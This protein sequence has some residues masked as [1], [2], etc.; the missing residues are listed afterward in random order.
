ML[1]QTVTSFSAFDPYPPSQYIQQ[2]SA[3][4]QKSLGRDTTLEIGYH[5]EHGLHLQRS[6]LINNADPGPG[7]LQPRRPFQVATFLPGT[8]FPAGCHG[9]QHVDSG[10]HRE[11]AGE[12]GAELVQRRIRQPPAALFERA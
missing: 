11:P 10:Q 5:G 2:W 7:A 12:H 3:S 4:V 1:G 6:H 9:R 8:V